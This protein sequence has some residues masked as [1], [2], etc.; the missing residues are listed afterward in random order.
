MIVPFI[1]T[2]NSGCEI[3]FRGH[4]GR[5][6]AGFFNSMKRMVTFQPPEVDSWNSGDMTEIRISI[7]ARVPREFLHFAEMLQGM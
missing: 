1:R 7:S 3:P 4:G 6:T 5:K 2:G